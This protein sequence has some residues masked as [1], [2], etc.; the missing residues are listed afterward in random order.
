MA[1][2]LL[3][4]SPFSGAGGRKLV[5]TDVVN[6]KRFL[7]AFNGVSRVEG[8]KITEL[9]TVTNLAGIQSQDG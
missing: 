3:R 2:P 1:Y 6:D 7:S 5:R 8:K 9:L 4:L